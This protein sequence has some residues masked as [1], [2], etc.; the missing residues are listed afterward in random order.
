MER[1][2]DS[3]IMKNFYK[4]FSLCKANILCG[5]WRNEWS[6]LSKVLDLASI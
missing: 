1:A 6:L 2:V 5:W 3:M 4:E